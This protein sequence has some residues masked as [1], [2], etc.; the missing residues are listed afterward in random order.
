LLISM[1]LIPT[2]L[3]WSIPLIVFLQLIL[4][5]VDNLLFKNK[6]HEIQS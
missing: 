1:I 2:L 4:S 6:Q 5:L 3:V